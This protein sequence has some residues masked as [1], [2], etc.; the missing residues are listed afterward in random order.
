MRTALLALVLLGCASSKGS[1]V[2]VPTERVLLTGEQGAVRSSMIAK[3]V[4]AVEAPPDSVY[5]ALRSVYRDLAIPLEFDI[6]RERRM[7]ATDVRKRRQMAG[8]PMSRFLNCGD[9]FTGPAADSHRIY[10]TLV[11][12]V[13]PSEEGST[14]DIIFT[15]SSQNLDGT[16]SDRLPCGTT[17]ALEQ[18]MRDAVATKLGV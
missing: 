13:K 18:W 10:M 11:S 2:I 9:T 4:L 15:A 5:L 16:S 8:Q 6:P 1:T 17:G 12:T 14:I 3:S 7:G